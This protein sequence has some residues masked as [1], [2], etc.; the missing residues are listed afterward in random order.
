[1]PI[2]CIF[3]LFDSIANVIS[4][5][6]RSSGFQKWG[7]LITFVTYWLIGMPL[8]YLAAFKWKMGLVGIWIGPTVAIILNALCYTT[9]YLMTDW[10]KMVREASKERE[11]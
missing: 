11:M 3:V 4:G 8:S 9:I 5:I 2:F 10:E 6:V 1:M 7:A